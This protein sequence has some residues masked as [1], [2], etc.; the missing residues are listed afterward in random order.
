MGERR[1]DGGR[2]HRGGDG[3]DGGFRR[4]RSSP[5][6][7]AGP[8]R[9]RGPRGPVL[10]DRSVRRRRLG[11]L[12]A[13]TLSVVVLLASGTAWALTGWVSGQ[14]N[15]FDVFSGLGE[16]PDPG[17]TGALNFLVIGSD[18]REGM[19][20]SSKSDL[21]VGSAEGRRSD[22]MMLVHVNDDRDRISV[23]GI[24]RDSW[25]EV[26]GVGKDKINAAYAHGGPQLTVRTVEAATHVRIDHYVEIDFTGFTEVVDAL[27]GI[28][29]CLSEPISDEKAK[30]DMAAGTHEVDGREALAFARTRKTAGGDLDRIGR[31][32]Q[33]MAALLDKAMSTDTL[34]DPARFSAFLETA[35]SSVTV[36]SGLDTAAI[37]EL[38]G[39]LR[40][41]GLDDV[42]FAQVPVEDAA[43]WTPRGDVAVTWDRKAAQEM[44]ARVAAD[45]PLDGAEP[46]GGASREAQG[47]EE[48][49]PVPGEVRVQVFNGIGTPG[50]GGQAARDLEATGFSVPGEARNWSSRDEEVTTVRHAP[51]DEAAAELV[52][53]AVP[54]A[55]PREDATL[56][57]EVQLVLGF[58]YTG[59]VPV[60]NPEPEPEAAPSSPEAGPR[61]ATARDNVCG[62]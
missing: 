11:L 50:L 18:S 35:L 27:G 39:Q 62:G 45:K 13:G 53:S 61:T 25:V 1:G 5:T 54:G 8:S 42:S 38:G 2:G 60:D 30:L 59:V 9:A 33:V 12:L 44:F 43:Y 37:S 36:D 41:V 26:P 31:Q 16:R 51:G 24:P 47:H 34:G 55:E 4:V 19:D 56:S 28:E 15:R 21:G 46:A 29:V 7:P 20:S 3:D 58:D 32:Q 23:V 14:I 17:P 48:A 57:G 40:S 22:T 49:P 6:P 52:A 10:P